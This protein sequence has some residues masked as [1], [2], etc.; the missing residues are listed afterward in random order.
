[1]MALPQEVQD[2]LSRVHLMADT[3]SEWADIDIADWKIIHAHLLSQ[4]AELKI[5][6]VKCSGTLANNLCPDHRDKQVG[7][8]CLACTIEKLQSRLADERIQAHL[9]ENTH[10]R[11]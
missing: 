4:D 3:E 8:P 2:A 7:N 10:D 11:A 9:S 1:M 5:L 6:R